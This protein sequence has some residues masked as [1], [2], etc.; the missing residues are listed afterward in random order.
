MSIFNTL[1][2]LFHSTDIEK[3]AFDHFGMNVK[4]VKLNSERDQNFY[5]SDISGQE[6]V[7]KIFNEAEELQIVDMQNQ[8]LYH[9]T[10]AA[11][12]IRV[13]SVVKTLNG[14]DILEYVYHGTVH[15]IR[16]LNYV[17]GQQLKDMDH[18]VISML[19]L[20][21]FLGNLDHALIGFIHPAAKRRFPWDIR[22]IDFI[23]THYSNLW[24]QRKC[25]LIDHFLDQYKQNVLPKETQLRKAVIHNDGNDHNV[26]VSDN[27]NTI[28]I[29]DFGDMVHTYIACEPAVCIAY[30]VLGKKA[31]FNTAAQLLKGYNQVFPL[32]RDELKSVI[33]LVCTRLCIT[34]TMAA[35]RKNL[36]PDNTYISVSDDLAWDFLEYMQVQDLNDWAEK[37]LHYVDR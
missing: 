22:N 29:I 15:L 35:Y 19:K 28:G 18:N 9:V 14:S 7:M 13:S 10:E 12:S 34:V 2:P 1:P 27:K 32:S 17:P 37:L 3:I 26:L 20:G 11:P 23:E 24:D 16:V 6:Y 8:V 36:F 5:L 4:A 31:P 30:M 33:Y 21:N 25:H